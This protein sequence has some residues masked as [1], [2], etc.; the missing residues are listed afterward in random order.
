MSTPEDIPADEGPFV[1]TRRQVS[2]TVSGEVVILHLDDGAYYGLNEV[3]TRIW[4]LLQEP[5]GFQDLVAA[6]VDEFD[7][8]PEACADDV[9]VLLDELGARGLV[10]APRSEGQ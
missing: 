10:E 6:V 7:V 9:R 5:R 8:T 4:E 2:C 1:A 3:G